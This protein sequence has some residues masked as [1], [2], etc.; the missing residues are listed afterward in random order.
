FV[1]HG[2]TDFNIEQRLQGQYETSLNVRGRVQARECGALLNNLFTREQR[3]SQ[4]Y[5][6]MSSP[7]QR[8]RE[9][10]QLAR[11]TLGLDPSAYEVDDRLMEISYGEWEGSTLPE[12]EARDPQLLARREEDKW[13]FKP[14]GGECYRDVAARV[15]AWYATVTRDTVVVA[16]GGVAR[17]L[18]ANFNILPEEEAAHADIAHGVVYVFAGGT[19]ARYA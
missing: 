17:A 15:G 9:T 5:A 8:A 19:M 3:Q 7:L 11:A 10:M 4:D 16:H 12:I 18:M 13:G 1:R 14:P 6:Y 2:E